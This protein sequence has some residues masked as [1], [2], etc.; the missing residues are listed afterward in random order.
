MSMTMDMKMTYQEEKAEKQRAAQL[1][2]ES[3]A[4]ALA[5]K[6]KTTQ[7]KEMGMLLTLNSGRKFYI[8]Y[9]NYNDKKLHVS[10]YYLYQ[11]TEHEGT[12]SLLNFKPYNSTTPS[13]NVSPQKTPFLIARDIERR[14][15]PVFNQL[16]DQ[17][18][19]RKLASESYDNLCATQAAGLAELSGGTFVQGQDFNKKPVSDRIDVARFMGG[20]YGHGNVLKDSVTF[21]LRSVPMGLA[22]K[23]MVAFK[24]Y[25]EEQ[26]KC[27]S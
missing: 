9:G 23:I 24:E 17:M 10:G 6:V 18:E 19:E 15:L 5:E 11:G 22:K 14:F 26:E 2:L 7:M 12:K 1:L 8:D 27:Q 3:V 16:M 4:V 21:E 25:K 13:I 20:I